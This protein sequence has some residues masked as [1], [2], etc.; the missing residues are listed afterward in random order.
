MFALS[1]L[2]LW[3]AKRKALLSFLLLEVLDCRLMQK[4]LLSVLTFGK[5]SSDSRL[6]AAQTDQVDQGRIDVHSL[7]R[8]KLLLRVA[9]LNLGCL[10]V[11]FECP[12]FVCLA[13]ALAISLTHFQNLFTEIMALC[14]L[15]LLALALPAN[16]W[17][18]S[19]GTLVESNE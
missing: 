13:H 17:L 7:G 15:P 6:H 9:W 1:H 10:I 3:E 12:L 8:L 14:F 2:V 4:Q 16:W 5:E 19:L 18:N 11:E